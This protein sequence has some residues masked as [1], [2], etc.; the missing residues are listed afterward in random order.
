M[1]PQAAFQKAR[2]NLD[3]VAL[4]VSLL[5]AVGYTVVSPFQ[6]I[7]NLEKKLNEVSGYAEAAAIDLC[8]SRPDSTL[9]RMRLNCRALLSK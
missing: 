6:R 2:R 3:A 4:I 1:T 7:D 9:A 5:T 8:L